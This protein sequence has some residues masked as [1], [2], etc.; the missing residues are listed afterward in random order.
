MKRIILHI[1]VNNAFLSWTAVSLLK[2]GFKYDIRDSYAVIGGDESR[3]AGIVLAKSPSA[4]KL[5]IITGETLYSARKK[6]KVLK[7]YPPNHK[8]YSEMSNQLFKLLSNYTPDIE[9]YSIDECFLDYTK[10][11][12]LYGDELAFA[13]KIK[14][15]IK[16][17]LGFTVNVGIGNNKLCAKMASE[18]KKPN[19][20]HTLYMNEIETK[21]WPL[22]ISELFGIGRKTAPKMKEL[23]INT[24]GDLANTD[25]NHLYKYFKNQAIK[26]VEIA[27]GID[28]SEVISEE[29]APKGISN[30]I[31]LE[32]DYSNKL[33][34]HK[35]LDKIADN[36]SLSLRKQGR[37]T[38]VIAVILRDKYFNNKTRQMKLKN[39]TNITSEIST[40]AK[41][42][43]D[44][45][46]DEE[47]VR[48]IGIRLDALTNQ[49]TYQVSL[50]ENI[51]E[52]EK[53]LQLEKIV[54]N[55]ND[56]FGPESVKKASFVKKKDD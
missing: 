20:V 23:G 44:E 34:L 46:W 38:G 28:D 30:T 7:V 12:K 56:K 52:R 45:L 43:F 9:I 21:M 1:D 5:G 15:E 14:D 17:K 50:F 53:K 24:I 36:V 47:P 54:D 10:V 32:Y 33:E 3:R 51:K 16:N 49:N 29:I 22:P 39:V 18:F 13:H 6:C 11:K 27:N 40:I 31:T 41:K 42:L 48:L 25:P 2:S 55:I 19:L 37:Y 26:Y 4:K 35:M 8:L